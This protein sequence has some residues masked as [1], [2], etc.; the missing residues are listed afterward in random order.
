MSGGARSA[1]ERMKITSWVASHNTTP[2]W[3]KRL[4]RG[5]ENVILS[6]NGKDFIWKSIGFHEI[7]AFRARLSVEGVFLAP[8]GPL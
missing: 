7:F 8:D 5:Q 4:G 3:P 6:N 1:P 2:N